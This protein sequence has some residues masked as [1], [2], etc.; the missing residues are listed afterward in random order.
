MA[1]P[2]LELCYMTA[3]EALASFRARTLSPVE[4]LDALIARAQA[5]NPKVNA[6][7]YDF[8]DRAREQAKKAEE[9]YGKTDGRLRALEGVPVAIKDFHPVKGEI[10]TFG[11]KIF[12]HHRPDYSAPTVDRLLRAGAIMHMRTTTPEFAYSGATHSPLFGITPNPWNLEYT[13]GGSSGGAGAAVAGGMTTL[14]DGTDGGG[15]IRIP[16]SACG[17]FG[18]KPPFGRNPLDR[19]HPMETILHYGPMVR[20]VADAALMQNVM[21]GPHPEDLCTLPGRVRLPTS[22]EGIKGWKIA[23][24]KDLGYVEVHPEV[25]RNT[26]AAV[27]TLRGLGAEVDEIDLGWNWGVLD[28]WMTWWEGLFAGIAGQYLP[29][30]QYEMDPYV[31]RLLENGLRHS[32][33]RIYQCYTFRGWMWQQLQPVL[34]KY[35]AMICPT[36]AVPAVKA[37]HDDADPDYRINGRVVQAY[38]GWV[39]THG[40]NLVSQCPVMSVPTGFSSYGVPTGMQIVGR[41]FDDAS[42]FRAAAAFEGA[43]NPWSQRPSI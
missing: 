18:Y 36:L 32:A 13:S 1:T 40:F 5:I 4:L 8:F 2:D 25:Q 43:T 23:F 16:A 6:I 15:S 27:E 24:T 11:S 7:T 3:S 31:V 34:K 41:P 42:V 17:I 28:C 22:Y 9:R 12:E 14:A 35:N 21:S 38:V 26:R 30:W 20:S 37:D 10:T 39:M 19:D 29:R 33:A